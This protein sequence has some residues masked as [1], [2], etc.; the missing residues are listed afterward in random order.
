MDKL[1][2]ISWSK[3]EVVIYEFKYKELN[4]TIDKTYVKRDFIKIFYFN[5]CFL[6]V[7]LGFKEPYTLN[8][9]DVLAKIPDLIKE[10]KS[11]LY[12]D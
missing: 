12:K 8:Q 3:E 1:G 6:R 11:I 7:E 5:R 10:A 9:W 2:I 4:K